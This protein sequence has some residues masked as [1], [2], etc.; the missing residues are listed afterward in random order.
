[1][2]LRPAFA[3]PAVGFRNLTVHCYDDIDWSIVYQLCTE[4]A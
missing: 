2:N 1:M 4:S 3:K